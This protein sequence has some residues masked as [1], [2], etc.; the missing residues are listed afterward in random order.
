MTKVRNN[1][2]RVAL[3]LAGT[4]CSLSVVEQAA[5]T[6][7]CG[8]FGECKALIE[9]NATD[10]DIGFHFLMDGNSLQ[11]A[12]IY[13]PS[14][15][16]IFE[17]KAKG[18]LKE[19]TMTETFVESAEPLC[20]YDPEEEDEEVV[21]LE[22]FLARWES[23]MY[24]FEGKSEERRNGK[25]KGKGK[26]KSSKSAWGQTELSFALP[27]APSDVHF[28]GEAIHWDAGEDLGNCATAAELDALVAAGILPI[29][30]E[31]V[32]IDS[33]EV[34]LEPDVESGDPLG[35]LTFSLRVAGDTPLPAAVSVPAEYLEALPAGTP[36]KIEVGALA[37]E[38]NATFS[39]VGDFCVS[40]DGECDEEDEEE[41]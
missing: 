39:E 28:D 29:H 30:P 1:L 16:K 32:D 3:T 33:W 5:G 31:N 23:G 25:G 24:L 13:D 6:A 15:K 17:D 14:G 37:S 26:G 18:A 12:K 36:L 21:S 2:L 4:A 38:D 9:I 35:A 11:S 10:G 41:D 27:A 8:D 34:V 19:Q 7:P 22:Q 20:W 40:E